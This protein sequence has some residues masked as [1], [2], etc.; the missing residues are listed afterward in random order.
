MTEP[1]L[2]FRGEYRFLSN[3]WLVDLNIEGEVYKSSEHY[4]MAMKTT[5]DIWRQRIMDAPSGAKAKR[6]GKTVP[7]RADWHE[8]YKNQTM[9]YALIHK[10]RI[11]EMREMLTATGD[12]YIEETNNW[13]DV[14]WGVCNGEGKNMLG[15]MLMYVRGRNRV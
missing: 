8:K 9:L 7:L 15:R 4:Y 3:F 13:N 5:N 12:A 2:G 6:I 11:P 14:Y 10:F 1:I